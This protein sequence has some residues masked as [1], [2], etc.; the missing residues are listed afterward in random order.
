MPYKR[1]PEHEPP[2]DS[3]PL[4]MVEIPNFHLVKPAIVIYS[5]LSVFPINTLGQLQR[6]PGGRRAYSINKI[7]T[8]EKK[9]Y[10]YGLDLK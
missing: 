9:P 2:V 6:I 10:I 3:P 4:E 5:T 1:T 8:K 7:S